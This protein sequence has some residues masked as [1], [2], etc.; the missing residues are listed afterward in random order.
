MTIIKE[1]PVA[2]YHDLVFQNE[3]K[4]IPR[5]ALVMMNLSC[6]FEKL[7]IIPFALEE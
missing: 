6:K 4:N 5:Q 3:A 1:T 7:N 2:A